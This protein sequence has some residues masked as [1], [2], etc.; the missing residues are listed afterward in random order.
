MMAELDDLD[1]GILAHVQRD[2][3]TPART[4]GEEVGLSAAAVQRRI[5][6]LRA[7]GVIRSV[8]AEIDPR[9]VGAAITCIVT[10]TLERD[11]RVHIERLKAV[12]ARLP[13]V[14]QCFYVTGQANFVLVVLAAD[15]EAYVAFTRRAFLDDP[16]IRTFTTHVVLDRV[17]TC[18]AVPL[19]RGR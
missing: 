9:S 7:A 8:T 14:Q 16:D 15:M 3:L 13:E 12:F 19:P 18:T 4:I 5:K 17:K 10:V 2:A 11:D 6:R 1:V